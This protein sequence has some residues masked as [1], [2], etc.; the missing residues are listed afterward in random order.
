M[1]H[2]SYHYSWFMALGEPFNNLAHTLH[3]SADQLNDVL[4]AW[5][6]CIVLVVMGLV[7]RGSLSKLQAQGGTLQYVPE[8]GLTIR[9][10]F[11]MYTS[12]IYNMVAGVMGKKDAGA[13]FWLFGGLFIY[14][15]FGNL[16]AL[17]PGVLPP[18]DDVNN[19]AAMA[20]T[21][22][23]VFNIAGLM[24]NG[25][26]Y[27]KHLM[28]PVWWLAPLM[29]LI[30]VAGLLFRPVSLTLRL[31]GNMNGD[32]TV[33]GIM[34]ELVPVVL[35]SI[36]LG[37]GIFVSFVQAFVFTLLTGVYIALAVAHEEKH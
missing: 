19:N 28:G 25:T 5:T 10:F 27:I 30:E 17:L 23:L 32:H 24:R 35:P 36:F 20:F 11:E 7:A 15:L 12:A 16:S 3:L 29:F 33:F 14:I 9:N 21:V 2:F 26:H 18:T 13:F 22:F 34:T 8:S 37:L 31:A 1:H 4:T 6:I